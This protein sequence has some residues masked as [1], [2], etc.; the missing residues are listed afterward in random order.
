MSMYYAAKR[1]DVKGWVRNCRDG[2]VEAMVH[3]SEENVSSFIDW[4]HKGPDLARVDEV[5][6]SNG[7]GE[8]S[9]FSVRDN[10]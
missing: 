2:S 3:G 7:T 8:F 1:F 4:A 10:I 9:E 5:I 6:V